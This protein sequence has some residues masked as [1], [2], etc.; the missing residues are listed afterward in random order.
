MPKAQSPIGRGG[1]GVEPPQSFSETSQFLTF[2]IVVELKQPLNSFFD[3][4]FKVRDR[5]ET[6]IDEQAIV[7]WLFVRRIQEGGYKCSQDYIFNHYSEKVNVG[8]NQMFDTGPNM[9]DMLSAFYRG[10]YR[11]AKIRI[12]YSNHC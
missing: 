7:P 1:W 4:F 12:L 6:Y 10:K 5:Y 3:K 11:P 2:P 9:Q 8:N